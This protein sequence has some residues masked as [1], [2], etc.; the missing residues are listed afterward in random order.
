[1]TT[2]VHEN[3]KKYCWQIMKDLNKV[4][5]NNIRTIIE[6]IF[7]I[8]T[9]IFIH[10]LLNLIIILFVLKFSTIFPA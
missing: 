2:A 1:M 8:I 7:F 9:Y 3:A 6:S 10:I 5:S 4:E